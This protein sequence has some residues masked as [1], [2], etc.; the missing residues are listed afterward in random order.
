MGVETSDAAALGG[1]AEVQNVVPGGPA[2]RAGLQPG[3]VIRKIDGRAVADSPAVA[4]I[5]STHKPGDKVDVEVDRS[6]ET[7][8]LQTTLGT[9]PARTP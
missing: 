6:G 4:A 5:V 1:G 3:D 8:K 2:E 9:R 7:K